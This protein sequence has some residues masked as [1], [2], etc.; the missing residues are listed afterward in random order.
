MLA[1]IAACAR[2]HRHRAAR[3]VPCAGRRVHGRRRLHRRL[4]DQAALDSEEPPH[5]RSSCI[6][7]GRKGPAW[8][9]RCAWADRRPRDRPEREAWPARAAPQE[10]GARQARPAPGGRPDS[11]AT[12]AP[13]EHPGAKGATGAPGA[14]GATGAPRS[15][16]SA[17]TSTGAKAYVRRGRHSCSRRSRD[18][19]RRDPAPDV[20]AR[21]PRS[22]AHRDD[23][24]SGQSVLVSSTDAALGERGRRPPPDRR[25]TG[26]PAVWICQQQVGGTIGTPHPIDWDLAQGGAGLADSTPVHVHGRPSRRERSVHVWDVRAGDHQRCAGWDQNDWAYT[27]AEVISG[28]SV[29]SGVGPS[30]KTDRQR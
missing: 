19:P 30:A 24:P 7:E 16:G 2:R 4:E 3:A 8:P 18:A 28:A 23:Q 10:R 6:P 26:L 22:D 21:L 5:R 14:K 17:R 29:L 12:R 1:G 9:D 20:D 27:I 25:S 11:R 13:R 15:Q